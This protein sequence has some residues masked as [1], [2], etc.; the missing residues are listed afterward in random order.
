MKK[1]F[2]LCLGGGLLIASPR[3]TMAQTQISENYLITGPFTDYVAPMKYS[4]TVSDEGERIMNGPISVLGKQNETYNNVTITGSYSLNASAKNGN[5]NGTMS[6]KATYHGVKQLLRGQQVE[7]YSYSFNGTFTNGIPNGTFTA[8]ATNFGSSTVTYKQGVLVGTYNV[9]ETINDRI[10]SIKGNFNDAGK[11]IGV[12][13]IERLGDVE[14]WEFINGIR[15]RLSSKQTESTPKQIE[16]ARKYASG[17]IT[18]EALE[19]EGYFPLQDSIQLG[20]YA[21]DLY[22]LK[23]IADWDKMPGYS[24]NKS[25]WIKYTYLYNLLPLPDREIESFIR[26]YKEKGKAPMRVEYNEIAKCYTTSYW[27]NYGTMS[28]KVVYNRRITDTQLEAITE[29]LDYYCRQNP[30]NTRYLLYDLGLF[31]KAGTVEYQHEKYL[32]NK[33]LINDYSSFINNIE[34]VN[35]GIQ[36]ALEG[37]KITSDSLYYIIPSNESGQALSFYYFPVSTLE[38]L[39]NLER[40]VREYIIIKEQKAEEERIAQEQ[41]AEEERIA[42]EQKAEE[43][44]NAAAQ[45]FI[46]RL[47]EI[48]RQSSK[49]V[50]GVLDHMII[51]MGYTYHNRVSKNTLK[52]TATE[53]AEAIAPVTEYNIIEIKEEGFEGFDTYKIRI[54]FI[55]KKEIIPVSMSINNQGGIIDGSVVIPEDILRSIRKKAQNKQA[56]SKYLNL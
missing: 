8:K 49:K 35:K 19:K 10:L 16:M 26:N 5:L 27:E 53:L 25:F 44:R 28:S 9:N 54:E 21:S 32:E 50:A 14:V 55:K 48:N 33:E 40:E 47:S 1:F 15:I 38:N 11:M 30:M 18:K 2:I 31:D 6:V 42:Q 22:F 36:T 12:W 20:D 7:D 24:F 45:L 51:E 52:I 39:Q 29:A 4:Y 41:K 13:N 34:I 46:N 23:F 3:T 37:K 17:L 56:V 43:E